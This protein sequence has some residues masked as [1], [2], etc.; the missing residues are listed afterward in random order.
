MPS[1]TLPAVL[2]IVV[3]IMLLAGATFTVRETEVAIKFLAGGDIV[4]T[5]TEPGLHFRIPLLHNVKKFERR[6]ITQNYPAETFLTSEGKILNV[7]FFVKWRIVDVSAYFRSTGGVEEN[8]ARRLG[9]IVKDSI[10]SAITRLTIQQI[11]AAERAAVTGDLLS[12]A[13]QA[14]KQ[15]GV[16][17]VD[18]RVRRIDLPDEV[19]D[20]VYRRMQQS[21]AAQA[22]KLRAEGEATAETTRAEADRQRTEI[23]SAAARDGQRVRGDGDAQATD[24]YARTFSRNPEFYSFY[25]SLQAYRSA[26]GRD[27]DVIVLSPDSEFFRYLNR[28]QAR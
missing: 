24:I 27:T 23:L 19:S 2:A 13:G 4:D 11:V 6:I 20:S 12:D 22:A 15:L 21:F 26:L 8:G 9:E 17:L 16:E 28:P 10:K 7:D 1:R 5:Y 14:V 25:R 3:A 18:V